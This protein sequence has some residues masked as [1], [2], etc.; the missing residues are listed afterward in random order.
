MSTVQTTRRESISYVSTRSPAPATRAEL[1][2]E[3]LGCIITGRALPE[4]LRP[5][6]PSAPCPA[7]V[8]L[9]IAAILAGPVAGAA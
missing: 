1:L 5:P 6:T 8:E 7:T 9:G 3:G 2:A 4:S